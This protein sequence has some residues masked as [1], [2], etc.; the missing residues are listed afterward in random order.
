MVGETNRVY[1]DGRTGL[2]SLEGGRGDVQEL[3][4]KKGD[5][6][7]ETQLPTAATCITHDFPDSALQGAILP[8]CLSAP[9]FALLCPRNPRGRRR[10]VM[11]RVC[12]VVT[13]N[14]SGGR[15]RPQLPSL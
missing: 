14:G 7:G 11:E 12:D 1:C 8:D 2:E 4:W 5:L 3:A 13:Q 15:G 6:K 9:H 10:H